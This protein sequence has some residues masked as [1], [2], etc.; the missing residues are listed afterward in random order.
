MKY[1]IEHRK[2]NIEFKFILVS[3]FETIKKITLCYSNKKLSKI[4]EDVGIWK[5]KPL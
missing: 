3:Q 4:P 1:T 5:F 2:I